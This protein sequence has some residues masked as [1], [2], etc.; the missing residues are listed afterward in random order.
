MQKNTDSFLS[1][2][3]SN[4]GIIY[5]VANS[6]C[7]N[8]ENRKDLIQE[9]ILQLW[10]SFHKYDPTYKLSTWMYTI[11]LNV[12]ISF[13]RKENRR[14]AINQALPDDILYLHE[15]DIAHTKNTD[16][17]QLQRFIKELKE[18]DRAIV[19]LYLE[20]NSQQEIGE[21]LGLTTTNVATRVSR[22]KQQLQQKFSTIKA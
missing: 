12:A 7:K 2:I 17:D 3:E 19:I 4:K 18:I 1:V 20:E 5:K 6:Y 10:L 8:E 15:D 9:I 22:I 13:Y 21:M 16:L 14:H 11:A